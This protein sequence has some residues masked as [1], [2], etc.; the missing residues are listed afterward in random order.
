M[1]EMNDPT[2]GLAFDEPENAVA[3]AGTSSTAASLP[4]WI[5]VSKKVDRGERLTA[6]EQFVYD[7][8]N[9]DPKGSE[10]FRAGLSAV[11]AENVADEARKTKE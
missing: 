11:L 4:D 5:E 9:A 2:A 7:F 1:N 8:D 10:K 6:L 3:L